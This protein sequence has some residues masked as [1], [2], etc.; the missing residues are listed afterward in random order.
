[1]RCLVGCSGRSGLGRRMRAK[2]GG[3]PAG[4]QRKHRRPV[5]FQP[6]RVHSVVLQIGLI[7]Q[8]AQQ[9]QVACQANDLAFGQRTLRAAQ[10][11]VEAIA[12]M[13]DDQFGQQGIVLR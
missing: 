9:R 2:A 10:H 13:P 6:T 12:G 11:I 4:K 5:L 1:M 7:G 3:L 8:Q